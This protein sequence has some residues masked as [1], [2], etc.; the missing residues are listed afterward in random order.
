MSNILILIFNQGDS[1][2]PLITG[3]GSNAVQVGIVSFGSDD[4]CAKGHATAY[5]R[6]S[7]Y[8]SWITSNSGV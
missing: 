5:T 4:G 7:A 3:S 8:R 2:G 6:V 1:G